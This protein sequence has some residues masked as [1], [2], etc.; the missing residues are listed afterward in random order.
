[1]YRELGD[2]PLI[3]LGHIYT[4]KG[5]DKPYL[6]GLGFTGATW[7]IKATNGYEWCTN[8][9]WDHSEDVDLETP[10][11]CVIYQLVKRTSAN[12]GIERE[13]WMPMITPEQHNQFES[14]KHIQE[15][16]TQY[17]DSER[18]FLLTGITAEEWD[19]MFSEED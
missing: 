1:M 2:V 9:L 5:Q 11:N 6:G 8:N 4:D 15:V 14:G 18:E 13:L 16:L 17:S 19:A 12:S 3:Y 7:N 10:D